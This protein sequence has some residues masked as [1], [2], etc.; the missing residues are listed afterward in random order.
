MK[1]CRQLPDGGA[2]F[3]IYLNRQTDGSIGGS[4]T[5][6][7]IP[8]GVP[9]SSLSRMV[10]V[11]EELMDLYDTLPQT[12]PG[13]CFGSPDVEL[14]ILFRQNYTWQ[15]RFRRPGDKQPT[16]FHSVLEMLILLETTLEQ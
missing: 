1:E 16:P 6:K 15:G 12:Q 10:I 3:Q 11:L 14:E 7:G 2:L 8:E 5:G 13:S 4:V 9:F